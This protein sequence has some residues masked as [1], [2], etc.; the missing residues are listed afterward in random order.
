MSEL[1]RRGDTVGVAETTSGGLLSAALWSSPIGSRVFKGAGVRLAYGIN[2]AAD[3]ETA[4]GPHMVHS[5]T[6]HPRPSTR[7]TRGLLSPC[8]ACGTGSACGLGEPA[9]LGSALVEAGLLTT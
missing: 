2:R 8:T 1:F 3:E 6:V 4:P 7:C 5:H 9:L